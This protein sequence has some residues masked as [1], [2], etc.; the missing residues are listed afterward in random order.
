MRER[1]LL[2]GRT[3]GRHDGDQESENNDDGN[4]GGARED[5]SRGEHGVGRWSYVFSRSAAGSKIAQFSLIRSFASH[6]DMSET[7]TRSPGWSPDT[8][9]MVFTELRPN[10]TGIRVA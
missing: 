6:C 1:R 3:I 10:S 7:I 2:V 5:E 8:T 9:S 4:H